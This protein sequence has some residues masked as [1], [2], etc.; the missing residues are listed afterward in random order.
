MFSR[1]SG[2]VIPKNKLSGS[3]VP[4]LRGGKKRDSDTVNTEGSKQVQR[5]IKWGPNLTMNSFVMKGRTLA[6][7]GFQRWPSNLMLY[8]PAG[9]GKTSLVR[10]VVQKSGS[11]LVTVRLYKECTSE[12]L[13]QN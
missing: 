4:V 7:Q 2:F 3:L 8:G 13:N 5:K 12:V 11:H 10:A 9:T 1:K 6:Y